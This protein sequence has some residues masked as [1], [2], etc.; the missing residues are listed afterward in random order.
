MRLLL[1]VLAALVCRGSSVQPPLPLPGAPAPALLKVLA[2]HVPAALGQTGVSRSLQAVACP[3]EGCHAFFTRRTALP[4]HFAKLHGTTHT[5]VQDDAVKPGV[6]KRPGDASEVAQ[7]KRFF[8]LPAVDGAAAAAPPA[9]AAVP[10]LPAAG[11]PGTEMVIV[12]LARL[13]ALERE[14]GALGAQLRKMP[15]EI[16]RLLAKERAMQAIAAAATKVLRVVGVDAGDIAA[17][18]GLRLMNS[19][20]QLVCVACERAAGTAGVFSTAQR[21][22]HLRHAVGQHLQSQ[23][24]IANANAAALASAAHDSKKKRAMVCGRWAYQAVKEALSFLAYPRFLYVAS[25]N[26]EDVGTMNHGQD[27]IPDVLPFMAAELDFRLAAFINK[28]LARIGSRLIPVSLSVDKATQLH[29]TTQMVAI[30]FLSTS[31]ALTY[32]MVANDIAWEGGT[33]ADAARLAQNIV[34]SVSAILTA[35]G[36]RKRLVSLAVD[37]AYICAKVPAALRA[38]LGYAPTSTWMLGRWCLAHMLELAINDCRADKVGTIK[39]ASCSWYPRLAVLVSM[40]LEGLT[41]GKGFEELVALSAEL[42]V[43]FLL[44]KRLC[45]TRFAQSELKV[46]STFLR[47]FLLIH[48]YYINHSD[49]A[50]GRTERNMEEEKIYEL[51]FECTDFA[52]IT[53][54]L[55]VRD[56]FTVISVYSQRFQKVDV[57]PWDSYRWIKARQTLQA[58]PL[59]HAAPLP[60]PSTTDIFPRICASISCAGVT[61]HRARTAS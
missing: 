34:T 45:I 13:R 29:R 31:G 60:A 46:Y 14:V 27:F 23:S 3:V 7:A 50:D 21:V 25:L 52:F 32:A 39:L 24:H 35:P 12:P 1:L 9:L 37:G 58:V 28:P 33:K 54:L 36:L 18:N 57:A 41:H 16:V 55:V 20:Q 40:L 47:D 22:P 56:I 48:Q 17:N 26:G 59:S 6:A 49:P 42:S 5:Y 53:G 10:A 4:V 30:I 38:L 2:S 19:G 44:P 43:K 11:A 51:S 61:R 15:A 8:Q